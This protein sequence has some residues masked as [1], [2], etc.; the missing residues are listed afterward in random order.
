SGNAGAKHQHHISR[1]YLI[2][3]GLDLHIAGSDTVGNA[4]TIG[5]RHL[6]NDVRVREKLQAELD[7]TW[8]DKDV[9]SKLEKL[10]KLP[11]LTAVIKKSL[12]LSH[13]DEQD[14]FRGR[15]YYCGP[16]GA[17]WSTLIYWGIPSY[18]GLAEDIQKITLEYI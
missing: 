6:V 17:T 16:W 11:Y 8:P 7:E 14:R 13:A 9:P 1:E 10:E 2:C 18:R 4:C 5:T 3:E 15:C 12:R